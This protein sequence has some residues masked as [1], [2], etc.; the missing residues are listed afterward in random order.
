VILVVGYTKADEGE[1]VSPDSTSSLR[2]LFPMPETPQDAQ[3]AQ[4]IMEGMAARAQAAGAFSTGGDRDSLNLHNND[5]ALIQAVASVN[6]SCAVAIMAG[7]AVMMENWKNAVSS[8][9]MLWYPGMEGG[10]AF[11]DIISGKVNPS[12]KLPFVIPTDAAHLPFFDKDA[13]SIEYD[14]W[15]G[16]RKLER[17]GNAPAFPFGFGLS[18]TTF[19]YSDLQAQLEGDRILVTLNVTNT[20]PTRG[21]EIV[22]IYTTAHGSKVER[23]K[24]E[25]QAFARVSLDANQTQAVKLEI[26]VAQLAYFDEAKG[27]FVVEDLEYE[28]MAAGHSLDANALRLKLSLH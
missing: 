15:H 18:Y 9:L 20:G 5:E 23:A 28:I 11:A 12:G 22:Q 4:A 16:H 14:L 2:T 7:S 27:D 10:Q 13:T 26:P 8:I 19:S 21:D 6:S 3:I 1:F 25:L 24:K 17:E